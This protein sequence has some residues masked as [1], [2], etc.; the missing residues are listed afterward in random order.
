MIHYQDSISSH[1][2]LDSFIIV[3]IKSAKKEREPSPSNRSMEQQ[4][5]LLFYSSRTILPND[6]ITITMTRGTLANDADAQC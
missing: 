3:S 2:L 1:F 4:V 5:R 6:K